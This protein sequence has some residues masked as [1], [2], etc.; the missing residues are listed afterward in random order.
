MNTHQA[1]ELAGLLGAPRSMN[2]RR[3][4]PEQYT[5]ETPACLIKSPRTCAASA[6]SVVVPV[7]GICDSARPIPGQ[8]PASPAG[9]TRKLPPKPSGAS[10][11]C[12]RRWLVRSVARD[13]SRADEGGTGLR[14]DAACKENFAACVKKIMP[15]CRNQ[16]ISNAVDAALYLLIERTE[17]SGRHCLGLTERSIRSIIIFT[18]ASS[19][20]QETA[21]RPQVPGPSAT[22]LL[23]SSSRTGHRRTVSDPRVFRSSR[24]DSGREDRKTR[25][26]ETVRR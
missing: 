25:G 9:L 2:V 10:M 26:S 12:A 4:A 5:L 13:G 1:S 11:P 3:E 15:P 22:G 18:H 6:P 19:Y 24:P 16:P 23:E 17:S 8:L 14:A 7:R 20:A 21:P